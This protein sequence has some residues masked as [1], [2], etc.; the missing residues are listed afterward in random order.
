MDY[1]RRLLLSVSLVSSGSRTMVTTSDEYRS[2]QTSRH[3]VGSQAIVIK[4]GQTQ[5]TKSTKGGTCNPHS[6]IW[7]VVSTKATKGGSSGEYGHN[8]DESNNLAH[9]PPNIVYLQNK[10]YPK[11]NNV[12]N[13]IFEKCSMT[14]SQDGYHDAYTL[15]TGLSG[16]QAKHHSTSLRAMVSSGS[17]FD[18]AKVNI[19]DHRWTMI[20]QV[21]QRWTMWWLVVTSRVDL[22]T[23]QLGQQLDIDTQTSTEIPT[24]WNG[25]FI[26]IHV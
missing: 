23:K 12:N 16:N 18:M 21:N 9:N 26:T 11:M 4:F 13:C 1:D 19:V 15:A 8:L 20:R 3:C 24:S 10:V 7:H 2:L 6:Q 25:W 17:M 5:L 14:L 22:T